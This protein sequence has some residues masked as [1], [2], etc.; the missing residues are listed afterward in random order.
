MKPEES[1]VRGQ[2]GL[3]REALSNKNRRKEKEGREKGKK[4]QTNEGMKEQ[5]KERLQ[6]W[7]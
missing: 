6:M 4:E 7:T 2:S 5:R 1:Q 3:H